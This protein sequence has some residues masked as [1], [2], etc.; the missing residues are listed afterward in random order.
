MSEASERDAEIIRAALFSSNADLNTIVEIIC[1]RSTSELKSCEQTYQIMYNS[2][3]EK[4]V[5]NKTKGSMREV[6]FAL[7]FSLNKFMID[8]KNEAVLCNRF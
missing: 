4:D 6:S 5:S 2:K 3:L 1:T 7:F 8:T